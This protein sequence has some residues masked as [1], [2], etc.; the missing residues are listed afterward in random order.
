MQDNPNDLAQY[1]RKLMQ[2]LVGVLAPLMLGLAAVS[3]PLVK[4]LLTD[5]W[6][7]CV[8]FVQI[9]C[10]Y[11]LISAIYI[12]YLQS[13]KAVGRSGLSL[14][15]EIIDDVLANRPAKRDSLIVAVRKAFEALG[16]LPSAQHWIPCRERLPEDD[17]YVLISKKPSQIS[18]NKFSVTIG[19]RYI[20][21]RSKK[22][23]WRDSGFGYLSDDKV[24]AWMPLPPVY[25][26][27]EK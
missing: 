6:L 9:C 1:N 25:R 4:L 14:A 22:A 8:P 13:F 16:H 10:I 17:V 5:K 2:M 18:G 21:R 20:N 7:L 12:A 3:T 15:M 24:L 23:E 19:M 11:Y 27:D 26:G